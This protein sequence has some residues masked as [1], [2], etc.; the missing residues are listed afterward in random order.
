[1]TGF[2]RT[3]GVAVAIAITQSSCRVG[4]YACDADGQCRLDG[5]VGTCAPPGWCAY[6]DPACDGGQRYSP[7]AGD[8]LADHCVD[9]ALGSSSG[10]SSSEGGSGS[11][12][13]CGDGHVDPGEECDDG[14]ASDGDGC[15][16]DCRRSGALLWAQDQQSG[17]A[18]GI[19]ATD[20]QAVVAA[21][22]D[23]DATTASRVFGI[24]DDGT[25]AWGPIDESGSIGARRAADVA[26]DDTGAW[27]VG[28]ED[29]TDGL[30]A[31]AL[32]LDASGQEIERITVDAPGDDRFVAA[33]GGSIAIAGGQTDA[34]AWLRALVDDGFERTDPDL[35]LLA[36]SGRD[37][38]ALAGV[39][40]ST[41]TLGIR[42]FAPG[43]AIATTHPNALDG[44]DR[45]ALARDDDVILASGA[46]LRR[47]HADGSLVWKT[48]LAGDGGEEIAIAALVEHPDGDLGIA[49]TIDPH[50][51]PA[52]WIAGSPGMVA[53]DGT[54]A[55]T[56][57]PSS[58]TRTAPP[59]GGG[60]SSRMPPAAPCGSGA[61]ARE[62]LSRRPSGPRR[63][64][65]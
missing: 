38:G 5:R 63:R 54:A 57:R 31:W 48:T 8:G 37:D 22:L 17:H 11:I 24:V 51:Q 65:R 43:G 33:V 30:R 45:I 52:P 9:G 2:A 27:I 21:T 6:A 40:R 61:R 28:D 59:T 12:P 4:P 55:W 16:H 20:D 19:V 14:N 39:F 46:A 15:N 26:R 32:H 64:G 1:M 29:G 10:S 47:E 53:R 44:A 58:S 49:A 23:V 50:G 3:L 13:S 36:L 25:I 62:R 41:G 60:Y 56:P 34:S 7:H 18:A 42:T 35:E